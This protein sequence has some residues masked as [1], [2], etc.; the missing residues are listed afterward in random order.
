LEL[1]E[2]DRETRLRSYSKWKRTKAL[3]VEDALC[4]GD[5]DRVLKLIAGSLRKK[6][7]NL[8]SMW[9]NYRLSADDFESALWIATMDVISR[10]S[11]RKPYGD[12]LLYE[13]L[14][15]AWKTKAID[16]I[17]SATK[18]KKGHIWH[19]AV[20]LPDN[21]TEL[22]PDTRINLEQQVTNKLL[23]EAFTEENSLTPNECK[24]FGVMR[25]IPD[26]SVRELS[27]ITGI[28]KS[29]ISRMIGDIRKKF[30]QKGYAESLDEVCLDAAIMN[31]R[32]KNSFNGL[33]GIALLDP[34]SAGVRK[35][36]QIYDAYRPS[37]KFVRS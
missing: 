12:Y 11:W 24:M 2:H 4:S 16:L 31:N 3:R 33:K 20:A 36:M 18:T 35:Q 7:N 19:S 10:Y 13:T 1:M 29:T 9:Y 30:F 6:A 27:R 15:L 23:L 8:A 22:H 17:R 21:F 25:Q 34:P 26:A 14:L 37:K 28:S 5:T 32:A